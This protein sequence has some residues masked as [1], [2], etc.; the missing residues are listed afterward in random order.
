M[1]LSEEEALA[2][3]IR[4]REGIVGRETELPQ[5]LLA[6]RAGRHLLIEGP[7]GAGKTVLA[8]AAS[9]ALGRR[10][11]RID[12][13]SRYTEQKLAG[14]FDPALTLAKGYN[15]ESFLPGPL[16]TAMREGALLFVNELNR[17][18]ESVQ[19]ILLPAM[20]EGILHVPHL[21]SVSARAGFQIIATQNPREFVATSQLSEALLDRMEWIALDY[22]SLEEEREIAARAS[23]FEEEPYLSQAVEITRATRSH[24]KI[25]RGASVRAAIAMLEILAARRRGGPLADEDLMRAARLAL[26][27]RIEIE[28]G[29]AKT[30]FS[31][32][33][34]E[35]LQDLIS[36][37]KKKP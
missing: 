12:G 7:V 35:I 19:N 6:L 4:E 15:E 10:V 25:R 22:Q 16:V 30:G 1:S 23:E 32:Q 5:L 9:R 37:S 28:S 36:R 20:D 26:P 27:T 17:M 31:R 21:G 14:T 24:P 29:E 33:I 13:D 34:E 3:E 8:Q 11:I 2:R 18:P